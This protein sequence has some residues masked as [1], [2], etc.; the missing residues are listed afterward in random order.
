VSDAFFC[1]GT[2][3][4][5]AGATVVLVT[6][7]ALFAIVATL[8]FAEAGLVLEGF[9][10]VAGFATVVAPRD[11]AGAF[12]PGAGATVAITGVLETAV[13]DTVGVLD[14]TDVFGATALF[15]VGAA[16]FETAAVFPAVAV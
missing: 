6:G 7:A 3:R 2:V 10:T 15:A 14:A 8:G 13:F 4:A 12:L 11:E 9:A 5:G 1:S 16:V